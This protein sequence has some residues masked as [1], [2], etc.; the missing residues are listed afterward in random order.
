MTNIVYHLFVFAIGSD[1]GVWLNSIDLRYFFSTRGGEVDASILQNLQY[2]MLVFWDPL[3][4][5]YSPQY[6]RDL[7]GSGKGDITIETK[8]D[9]IILD[10]D[11]VILSFKQIPPHLC[12][13]ILLLSMGG[14]AV[15]N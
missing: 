13:I 7:M 3:G 15:D 10:S 14:M 8:I 5:S 12:F 2:H 11:D 1:K 6:R 4:G 9:V